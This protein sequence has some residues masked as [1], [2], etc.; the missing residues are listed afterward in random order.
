MLALLA[1]GTGRAAEPA[2]PLVVVT[3]F[4]PAVFGRFKAAFE[5]RYPKVRLFVRSKKTSAAISFIQERLNEPADLFWVSAP[6]AFEVLKETGHLQPAFVD[7]LAGPP[8]AVGGYP[9]DEPGGYYR[10]FALS[11]YGIAFNTDYL[12]RFGLPAPARWQDLRRPEYRGH[13]AITAPSRSGTTHLIVETILQGLGWTDGWALLLEMSGNL[14]TITARSFGV[15][16]GLVAGRFGIG[17]TIDFF[18]L[19]AKA[20]GASV[21]FVYP[22]G[23]AF[24]P[25]SIGIVRRSPNPVAAQAFVDFLLSGPGQRMLFEAPIS[26]LPVSPAA[27]ADAP[28]GYPS[29]FDGALTAKGIR[30]DTRLSRQRYH[31]VNSLFDIMITYR[32]Q[33][34]RRAWLV[35]HQAE[36]A[37]RGQDRPGLDDRLAER[38]ARARALLTRVPLGDAAARDPEPAG[39][40]TRHKPGIALPRVQADLED[41]WRAAAQRNQDEALRLASGLLDALRRPLP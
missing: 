25:A 17:A 21:D 32:L 1:A 10:G 39:A 9:I 24:L 41:R 12:K 22:E 7:D 8:H 26:R 20:T 19:S 27:Y 34:L 40:F 6:D 23:T 29:P 14:A 37:L 18:G 13:L 11:G 31:L 5:A 15:L 28:P 33:V 16:D 2:G 36:A 4:P 35:V 38:L 3:S 30:F